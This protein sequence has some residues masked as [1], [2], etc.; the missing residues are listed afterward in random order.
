MVLRSLKSKCHTGVHLACRR[1]WQNNELQKSKDKIHTELAKEMEEDNDV[2][3][4]IFDPWDTAE[5]EFDDECKYLKLLYT[6]TMSTYN[7][8]ATADFVP[9][10]PST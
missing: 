3:E 8:I 2:D 6:F 4:D 7:K 1:I 9:P 5:H 10:N